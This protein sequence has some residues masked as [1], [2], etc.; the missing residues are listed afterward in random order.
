MIFIRVK[1]SC[2]YKMK[3][4]RSECMVINIWRENEILFNCMIYVML[5][6]IIYDIYDIF[7]FK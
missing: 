5:G 3:W 7:K 1:K 4:F 2:G 6:E